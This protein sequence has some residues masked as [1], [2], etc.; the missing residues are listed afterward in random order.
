MTSAILVRAADRDR[1][2]RRKRAS[3]VVSE[4]SISRVTGE[5]SRGWIG[6]VRRRKIWQ[7]TTGLRCCRRL[8]Y[9]G[10][11]VVVGHRTQ[12]QISLYVST[13][14]GTKTTRKTRLMSGQG[15]STASGKHPPR[16]A[17]PTAHHHAHH[18]DLLRCFTSDLRRRLSRSALSTSRRSHTPLCR[19]SV[20]ISCLVMCMCTCAV[21]EERQGRGQRRHR[22]T[23]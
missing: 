10:D 9:S 23:V 16:P 2:R 17:R 5:T 3:V 1:E 18:T 11:I 22:S 15:Y 8:P 4:V 14:L 21:R 12:D 13:R 6:D 7:V 20:M 19:S